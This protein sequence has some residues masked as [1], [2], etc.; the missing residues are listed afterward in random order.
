MCL[1]VYGSA[2]QWRGGKTPGNGKPGQG[3]QA[4]HGAVC[5]ALCCTCFAGSGAVAIHLA[6]DQAEH[7]A[8]VRRALLLHLTSADCT[9]RN[10]CPRAQVAGLVVE[11]TFLSVEDMAAQVSL[12]CACFVMPHFTCFCCAGAVGSRLLLPPP[13]PHAHHK[14][15]T[16]AGAA[17]AALGHW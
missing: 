4:E 14:L 9:H 1:A 11:N 12:I 2:R 16:L 5:F 10:C 7:R 13:P 6:R 8:C 15:H 17:A 3:E